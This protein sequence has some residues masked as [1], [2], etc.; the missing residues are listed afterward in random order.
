MVKLPPGLARRPI[1]VGMQAA[2]DVLRDLE[3]K[4]QD[5]LQAGRVLE[6][7]E[8]SQMIRALESLYT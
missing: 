5:A 8:L 6:A 4:R 2:N 1:K 3:I 7:V